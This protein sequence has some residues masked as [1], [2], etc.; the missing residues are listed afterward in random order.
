MTAAVFIESDDAET[1]DR[2][3][4]KLVN[5]DGLA[6]GVDDALAGKK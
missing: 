3:G 6:G 1:V 5:C 2:I 4:L